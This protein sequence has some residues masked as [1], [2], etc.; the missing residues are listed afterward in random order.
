MR[1]LDRKV[2]TL[3]RKPYKGGGT[4]WPTAEIRW[5][6]QADAMP[7]LR[8]W[9]LRGVSPIREFRTDL[10]LADS[11]QT[12]IGIKRRAGGAVEVKMLSGLPDISL[13]PAMSGQAETWVKAESVA[14]PLNDE[15]TIAVGKERLSRVLGFADGG[16]Q[17]AGGQDEVEE[18]LAVEYTMVEA[19]GSKW[20]TIAFEAFGSD[21]PVRLLQAGITLFG[22]WPKEVAGPHLIGGYPLWLSELARG[23]RR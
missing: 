3:L 2:K 8:D 16:W 9:V 19:Q 12:D 21:D 18:G 7:A 10:Y 11:Q 13:P 15:N 4:M 20:T 22:A 1:H 23:S 6:W 17:E 5:W 14:L